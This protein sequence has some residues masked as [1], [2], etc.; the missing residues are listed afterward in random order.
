MVTEGEVMA[1]NMGTIAFSYP[2]VAQIEQRIRELVH[3]QITSHGSL[4]VWEPDTGSGDTQ[5]NN[6]KVK[7]LPTALAIA[8]N[9][10]AGSDANALVDFIPSGR[11]FAIG[12]SAPK[13]LGF[14]RD[15]IDDE[16][17]PLPH[18]FSNVDGH[19]A[20]L[21]SL[22]TSLVSGAIHLEG[23][24]TVIDAVAW[25]ID[26]DAS[27]EVDVGLHWEDNADGTQRI[28]DDPGDPDVSTGLLGWILAFLLGFI[29]FGLVGVIIV[30]VILVVVQNM[31]ESIGG[32]LAHDSANN[33]TGI[34]ALP[35]QLEHI[36]EIDAKFE[37]PIQI[38]SDGIVF[39]G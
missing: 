25:S 8:V 10:G 18:R 29:T 26:V 9:G 15:A 38:A 33:V 14:I 1:Q 35:E 37:N 20:D 27:F 5:I 7:A 11:E 24:V 4:A 17:A 39:S 28:E 23:D 31:A 30:V 36:G 2:T 21:T 22:D 12:L 32:R 19:D 34:S 13:V 6:V 16:F 3:T